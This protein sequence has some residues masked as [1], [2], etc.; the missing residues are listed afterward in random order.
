M[1]IIYSG[2]NFSV[3]T[4]IGKGFRMSTPKELSANGVNYH[5][6]RYEKGNSL[7]VAEESWQVD[8]NIEFS[9]TGFDLRV[10]PFLNYFPEYF[11]LDPSYRL[12]FLYGAGN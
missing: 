6:F 5:F 7:L 9:G 1:G 3:K 11:Y 10:S 8:L 12:D 2:E 4:N